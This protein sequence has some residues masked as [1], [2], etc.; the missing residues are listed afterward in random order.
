MIL[1]LADVGVK[2]NRRTLL[3]KRSSGF[4]RPNAGMGIF[5]TRI[6][7][8][9]LVGSKNGAIPVGPVYPLLPRSFGSASLTETQLVITENSVR[10]SALAN[11]SFDPCH[12]GLKLLDGVFAEHRGKE[13][14]CE[15]ERY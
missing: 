3:C 11:C 8:H 6:E 12:I 9:D 14:G 5:F 13:K 2:V 7:P 15:T 4:V 1:S 10:M